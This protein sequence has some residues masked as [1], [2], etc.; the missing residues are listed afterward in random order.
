EKAGPKNLSCLWQVLKGSAY[1]QIL[2]YRGLHNTALLLN[3]YHKVKARSGTKAA[4]CS[5]RYAT[6]KRAAA[7]A[8]SDLSKQEKI[9]AS[10]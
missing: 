9:F 10:T 4:A 1:P 2:I 3:R 6:D 5:N 7:A 8:N